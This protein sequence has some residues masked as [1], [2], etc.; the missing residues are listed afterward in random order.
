MFQE[1]VPVSILITKT[2]VPTLDHLK[3]KRCV[4]KGPHFVAR[5]VFG[6]QGNKASYLTNV[7]DENITLDCKSI[8]S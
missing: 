8:R 1:Q 3:Y 2:V 7:K 4:V 6:C 5:A